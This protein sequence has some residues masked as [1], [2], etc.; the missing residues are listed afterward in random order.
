MVDFFDLHRNALRPIDERLGTSPEQRQSVDQG[1]TGLDAFRKI[2]RGSGWRRFR[3]KVFDP[4]A[5]G[6]LM[7]G[8]D[9]PRQLSSYC[10]QMRGICL[11]AGHRFADEGALESGFDDLAAP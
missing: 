5:W 2:G 8:R 1:L 11:C 7:E 3:R 6:F 9:D 4:L 10:H